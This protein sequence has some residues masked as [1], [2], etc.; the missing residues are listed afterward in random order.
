MHF[1]LQMLPLEKIVKSL[2]IFNEGSKLTSYPDLS[3]C[4]RDAA[5]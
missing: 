2:L 4:H 5:L 3:D 1:Q